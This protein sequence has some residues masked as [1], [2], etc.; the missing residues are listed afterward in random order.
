MSS[1]KLTVGLEML[2]E[3]RQYEF[4]AANGILQKLLGNVLAS[5][6][7]AKYRRIKTSNAKI[8]ALLATRGVRATLIGAGFV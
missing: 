7:E 6:E 2:S 4:D 8:N 5:P 3:V 1:V